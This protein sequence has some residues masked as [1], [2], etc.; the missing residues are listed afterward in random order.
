MSLL[1]YMAWP[2]TMTV[3]SCA[4]AEGTA[5]KA[6]RTPA[7]SRVRAVLDL[8]RM[9]FSL[10]WCVSCIYGRATA[11]GF[12]KYFFCLLNPVRVPLRISIAN[13]FVWPREK[14]RTMK[15]KEALLPGL[16]AAALCAAIA[17]PAAQ[18]S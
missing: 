17:A 2:P 9:V 16:L 15:R 3:L 13:I 8:L 4:P 7:A 1:G 14:G 11:N 18:A 6:A 12:K 5:S 10:L